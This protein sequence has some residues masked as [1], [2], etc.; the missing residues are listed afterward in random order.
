MQALNAGANKDFAPDTVGRCQTRLKAMPP[1][2]G[3]M[4]MP[5]SPVPPVA[6]EWSE[7][8]E[9]AEKEPMHKI[10][11]VMSQSDGFEGDGGR[12]MMGTPFMKD[13]FRFTNGFECCR[14]QFRRNPR[15]Q[16]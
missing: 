11:M 8:F 5:G 6:L 2:P 10:Q 16:I 3:A 7:L 4:M 12:D 1:V 9:Q 15:K 14:G 13:Y